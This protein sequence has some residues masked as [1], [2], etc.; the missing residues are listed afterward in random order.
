MGKQGLDPTHS[1]LA[2]TCSKGTVLF[3]AAA[4]PSTDNAFHFTDGEPEEEMLQ[5]KDARVQARST[6]ER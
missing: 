2:C 6:R 3:K 1:N 4:A 5:D